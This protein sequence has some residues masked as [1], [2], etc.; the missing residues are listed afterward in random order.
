MLYPVLHRMEEDGL[1][2]S[3]W[4]E[5]ETG[6][7]RKYYRIREEGQRALRVEKRQWEAVDKTLQTLWRT[8][9]NLT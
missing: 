7:R 6:R 8:I 3:E 1:I 4:K 5:A 9:P 2:E